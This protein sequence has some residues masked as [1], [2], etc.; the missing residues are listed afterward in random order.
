[1][2][3]HSNIHFPSEETW[4]NA[5]SNSTVL[6]FIRARKKRK[7][8]KKNNNKKLKYNYSPEWGPTSQ[9]LSGIMLMQVWSILW[10]N[11]FS[12][13]QQTIRPS[14]VSVDT[15]IQVVLVYRYVLQPIQISQG[16]KYS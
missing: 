6:W 1:M 5:R 16:I 13:L 9:P 14:S 7:Y 3:R 11:F 12:T 4:H 10:N 15:L 2:S 8:I